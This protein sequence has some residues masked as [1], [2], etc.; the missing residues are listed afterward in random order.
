[1]L[2]T[3][4]SLSIIKALRSWIASSVKR[5]HVGIFTS[6]LP[7]PDIANG[8]WLSIDVSGTLSNM[9]TALAP[10]RIARR[11]LSTNVHS[12]R[13]II[14]IFPISS[15]LLRISVQAWKGFTETVFAVTLF[16][17]SGLKCDGPA[18]S[19]VSSF[20]PGSLN[21]TAWGGRNSNLVGNKKEFDETYMK[22][23]WSCCCFWQFY[24]FLHE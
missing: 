16:T 18:D 17:M 19:T 10:A 7:S 5:K 6:S 15:S 20:A 4:K 14:A 9:M 8:G 3:S 22:I 2:Q 12:P 13:S 24:H 23:R 21:D 11:A 1:M